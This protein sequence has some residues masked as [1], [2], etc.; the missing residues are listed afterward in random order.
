MHMHTHGH[1]TLVTETSKTNNFW[2]RS[3]YN[4]FLSLNSNPIQEY[5]IFLLASFFGRVKETND[6]TTFV[7]HFF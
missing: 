7:G 5:N 1:Q 3:F 4:M 6:I 2:A